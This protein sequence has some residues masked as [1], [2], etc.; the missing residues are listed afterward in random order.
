MKAHGGH[1]PGSVAATPVLHTEVEAV[2]TKR[3]VVASDGIAAERDGAGDALEAGRGH[4]RGH[5]QDPETGQIG[6]ACLQ[7]AAIKGR[8]RHGNETLG[9]GKAGDPGVPLQAPT[10]EAIQIGHFQGETSTPQVTAA[11]ILRSP[12]PTEGSQKT[13]PG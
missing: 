8:S 6:E 4:A 7:N 9:E 12:R 2:S 10:E 11:S 1:A 5:A 3:N 13:H